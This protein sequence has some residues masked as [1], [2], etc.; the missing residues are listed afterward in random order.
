ML[1]CIHYYFCT[2]ILIDIFFKYFFYVYIR[3]FKLFLSFTVSVEKTSIGSKYSLITALR[4]Y[5]VLLIIIFYYLL[6]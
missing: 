6:K 3:I 2:I 1:N 4:P 5:Y